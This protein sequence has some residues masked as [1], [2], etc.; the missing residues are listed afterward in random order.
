MDLGEDGCDVTDH[1]RAIG[2]GHIREGVKKK[3]KNGM[4]INRKV[5]TDRDICIDPVVEAIML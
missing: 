5:G 1:V 4:K 2:Y 3:R